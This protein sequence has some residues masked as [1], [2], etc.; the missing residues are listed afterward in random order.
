MYTCEYV[1]VFVCDCVVLGCACA[2]V[3]ADLCVCFFVCIC[4][5][6]ECLCACSVCECV[7]MSAMH[8][9]KYACVSVY[10]CAKNSYYTDFVISV[11]SPR[12]RCVKCSVQ[13]D[14]KNIR[15]ASDFSK[16]SECKYKQTKNTQAQQN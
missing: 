7:C 14:R 11:S 6:R 10:I 15:Y 5:C 16:N 4:L 8:E 13:A 3:C 2:C 12:G 9:S 1:Q